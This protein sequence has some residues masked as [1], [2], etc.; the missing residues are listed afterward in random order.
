[1]TDDLVATVHGDVYHQTET[2]TSIASSNSDGTILPAYAVADFRVV[3]E[4]KSRGWSVI[5]NVKNAFN[6]VYL[7]RGIP[8]GSLEFNTEVPGNPRTY[9]IT[10]RIKF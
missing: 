8:I 6:R 4:S 1:M 5:A 9:S 3:T 2:T 7:V 10:G